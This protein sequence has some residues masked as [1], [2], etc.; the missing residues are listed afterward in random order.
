MRALAASLLV[1]VACGS[2]KPAAMPPK[3]PNTELIVG[4]FERRP[5][6]GTTAA[7]FRGDG[8]ITIAHDRQELDSKP[9]AAGTWKLDKDELTLSYAK[10][11]MCPP[12]QPGTYK[13]VISRIGIRFT[14]VDDACERRAKMD[15]QTWYR[16]K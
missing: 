8:S 9:L 10:G 16:A 12:G 14:K 5:P 3:R 6:D 7:R 11:E 13:V 15:G 4:E 1:V 2:D